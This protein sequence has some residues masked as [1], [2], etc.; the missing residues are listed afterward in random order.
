MVAKGL[1]GSGDVSGVGVPQSRALERFVRCERVL[2]VEDAGELQGVTLEGGAVGEF[3]EELHAEVQS[4]FGEGD[5]GG[6]AD[7]VDGVAVG[8]EGG[9][10]GGAG[11]GGGLAR[12]VA[13]DAELEP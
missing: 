13:G 8:G 12:L 3:F 4:L 11:V 1:G 7:G 2:E 9:C 6:G 5:L 10:D